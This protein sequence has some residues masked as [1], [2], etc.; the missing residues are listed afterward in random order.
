MRPLGRQR[1]WDPVE[2]RVRVAG[3]IGSSARAD[4]RRL[5][6]HAALSRPPTGGDACPGV[7]VFDLDNTL[8]DRQRAFLQWAESFVR[9]RRLGDGALDV[10]WT[11]DADGQ[12][13]REEMFG[14]ARRA[15][16]LADSVDE[17]IAQYRTTYASFFTPDPAVSEALGAL[18]ARGWGVGVATNGPTTQ[19]EKL[20]NAGLRGLLDACGVSEDLGVSKPDPE[21]FRRVLDGCLRGRRLEGPRFMVGDA[22]VADIAGGTAAQLRTIW[23][24]R[25][26]TWVEKAY[27]PEAI[28]DTVAAAVEYMLTA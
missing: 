28:V 14:A 17:L 18:R 6:R 10:L 2:R 11:L 15:L 9:A 24:S 13:T 27:R 22:P 21:I 7:A 16:G 1:P 8:V 20:D 12:A 5:D 3:T 4:P 25:G 23:M 26:R 19:W